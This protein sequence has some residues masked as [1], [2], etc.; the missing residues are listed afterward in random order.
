[1][2]KREHLHLLD[3]ISVLLFSMLANFILPLQ[4]S[5]G[6]KVAWG[7][8]VRLA[9]LSVSSTTFYLTVND[10]K[11]IARYAEDEFLAEQSLQRKAAKSID[12]RYVEY[13]RARAIRVRAGFG[14]ALI[15]LALFFLEPALVGE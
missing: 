9:L 15:S 2:I 6:E 4:V 1:M 8:L 10:L 3:V 11:R 5:F 7:T 12:D 13:A 14:V